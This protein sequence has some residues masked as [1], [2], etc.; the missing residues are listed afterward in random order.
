MNAL[1]PALSAQ[2]RTRRGDFT[3]DIA[4]HIP[5]RGITALFGPSGCGKTT[6]LRCIA[7]LEKASGFIHFRGEAWQTESTHLAPHQRKVG[8]VFQEAN[9]FA[10]LTVDGNLRYGWRRTPPEERRITPEQ[11]TDWLGLQALRGHY[12]AQLSGGQRQRVAIA[13]ALL[14]NPQLLLMDEPLASLDAAAKSEILDYLE[15]LHTLLEIPIV[16]VS[17]DLGEVQRLA[18]YIVLMDKGQLITSGAIDDLLSDPQLPIAQLDEAAALLSGQVAGHDAEFNLTYIEVSAGRIAL[19]QQNRPLGH[20][21]RVRVRANDVSLALAA[22]GDSSINNVLPAEVT[23]LQATADPAFVLVQLRLGKD[24]ILAR[25]TRKSVEGL[26]IA[27]GRRLFAQV[28][29]VSLMRG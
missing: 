3:L 28:K 14:A 21:V 27:V 23:A 6:A 18:D 22:H 25:I 15:Q 5:E 11:A 1:P 12:P 20:R 9:L 7:G 29:T 4:L 17:H 26:S 10:H 8:L 24:R 19:T 2:L 13:R 16:Y